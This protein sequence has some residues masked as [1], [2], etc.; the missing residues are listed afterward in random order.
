LK[1]LK[2]H[3]SAVVAYYEGFGTPPLEAMARGVPVLTS[4]CSSLPGAT[5]DVALLMNP[6]KA[7]E[8]AAGMERLLIVI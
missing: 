6:L 4:N 7:E 8:I 3:H 5:G 2:K 1:D